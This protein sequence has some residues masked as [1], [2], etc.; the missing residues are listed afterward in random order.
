MPEAMDVDKPKDG[1]DK[2]GKDKEEAKKEEP[3]P[4]PPPLTLRE[5]A[6]Q[7]PESS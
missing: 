5:G 4:P 1:K 3:A 7:D 6:P 2:G